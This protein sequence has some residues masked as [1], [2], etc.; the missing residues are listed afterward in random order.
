MSVPLIQALPLTASLLV[1]AGS[2]ASDLRARIIPDAFAIL[3][4]LC[5][6]AMALRHGAGTLW[7]ALLA[8]ACVFLALGA[9]AHY[10]IIGGGD[11]KL[12]AAVCLL[13]PP[14]RIPLLLVEIALAGGVLSC[15]YLAL[16]FLLR[17]KP[18]LYRALPGA[19]RPGAFRK[20]LR[21]EG[22]RIARG[23]PMPYALAVLGGVTVHLVRELPPCFS[24]MSCSL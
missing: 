9:L 22:A 18:A 12:I 5:G 15:I 13:V 16:G 20:W 8:A 17:F 10:N 11:V 2:A 1:L 19:P 3:I 6:L 4:A 7:I 14:D 24:A 23:Y 21:R